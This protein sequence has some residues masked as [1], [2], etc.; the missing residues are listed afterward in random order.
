MERLALA[1]VGVAVVGCDTGIVSP[2]LP[3]GGPYTVRLSDY[4][5]LRDVGGVARVNL[6]DGSV[7]G[8]GRLS[9]T[10]FAAYGL[11]CTH[12]G[13]PVRVSGAGWICPSH[14]AAFDT[15]GDVVRG[16]ARSPLAALSVSYDERADTLT[17]QGTG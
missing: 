4:P 7:I 10:E 17:V 11:A 9:A 1:A 2:D 16:P 8:V 14:D 13:T 5:V 12:E 15:A 6:S 3:R